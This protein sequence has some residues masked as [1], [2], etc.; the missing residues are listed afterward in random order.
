MSMTITC[1]LSHPI[2]HSGRM[3]NTM[4]M[5]REAGHRVTGL[6]WDRTREQ[7]DTERI[8]GCTVINAHVPGGYRTLWL[9]VYLP[10]WWVYQAIR[11]WRLRPD[12]IYTADLD[13]A[14]PSLAVG[15]LRSTP[16]VFD[17]YDCY[18]AR[19]QTVPRPFLFVLRLLER[20]CASLAYAVILPDSSRAGLLGVTPARLLIAPNCPYDAVGN[21]PPKPDTARPFTVF[22]A[23]LIA[24]GR[25][26]EKL[27]ALT[28]GTDV[29]VQIAGRMTDTGYAA[30][31]K[32]SPHVEYLGVLS[33]EQ[34][35]AYTAQSDAVWSYYDPAREI[36]RYAN[37][38][39][40]YEAMMCATAVLA[41]SEPRSARIVKSCNCG[42]CLPYA[43]DDGLRRTLIEWRDNREV[44]RELGRNGRRA[45]ELTWNWPAVSAGIQR[46]VAQCGG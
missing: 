33:Q 46:M 3:Q 32:A 31:F 35:R 6:C 16:V 5:L 36:N 44:V 2:T 24:P 11:L 45:F 23:G 41:N 20:A 10:L 38:T 19:T 1:V 12:V 25:G 9:C 7:P 15:I 21:I 30:A 34:V 22:Y 27:I 13:T 8:E 42:S 37:S 28:T 26:L 4:R 39:K 14:V 40:L 43:D 18:A 29:R 17:V